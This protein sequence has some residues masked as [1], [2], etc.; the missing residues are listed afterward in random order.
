VS[1]A[2]PGDGRRGHGPP[3]DEPPEW[4]APRRPAFG[5]RPGPSVFDDPPPP[6]PDRRDA[7]RSRRISADDELHYGAETR[8]RARHLGL[9]GPP[10]R[11]R[12]GEVGARPGPARLDPRVSWYESDAPTGEHPIADD[13]FGPP[14][15]SPGT[16][17]HPAVAPPGAPPEAPPETAVPEPPSSQRASML[18]AAGILLSR[19]SGLFREVVIG[20]YLGTSAAADAFKAALRVPNLMQN[21]LGEGVLSASFIPVYARLRAEGDHETARKVA[22]SVAGLLIV[23]AGGLSLIGV[24]FAEPVTRV[25]VFGYGGERFDLTVELVRIMFPG[26]GFLVLSAWCLGVLNSHR[27]FFLSYVAPVLWNAAQ[28][29]VLVTVALAGVSRRD[30]AVALAWGVLAGGVLQ[31]AVQ[32]P[33]VLRLLGGLRLSLSTSNPAVRSVLA[34]FGPVVMGRGVVQ[35]MGYVDLLLASFLVQGGVSSL[36][37]A[38]VLYLLPIS[39]FGMSVA[40]AELPSLSSVDVSDPDRRRSFRRRM[41][42]GMARILFYVAPTATL[43]LVVGDVIV[44]ALFQRGAM[45]PDD[46]VVIWFV[47]AAFSLGLP[48]MTTSRLLQNA[49]YAL[50][51]ARTPARLAALR[52]ITSAVIGLAIM[53]P[54]DR[55]TVVDGTVQGWGDLLSLGP[56][57]AAVREDPTAPHLGILGLALGAA[58][59]AWIEYRLL[60]RSVAW[61]IGR[62]RI[63]GRWLG[64]IA[65]AC[66]V[67]ALVAFGADL[68]VGGLHPLVVAPLVLGSAGIAYLGVT[69]ALGIPEADA[70][71]GRVLRLAR[72]R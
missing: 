22:G 57:P 49:L 5:E 55:L 71:V 35:I 32:L 66:I 45:T 26:I 29:V 58:V 19:L 12:I 30:M 67:T 53:F 6:A 51:D 14:P 68:L 62:S 61:R 4:E 46:T 17:E 39:V 69:Q 13:V 63:G 65:T 11:D 43:F 10:E 36:T 16:G 50:D 56:L 25:I 41:E 60:S 59:A 52:V 24:L 72:R 18:V 7:W 21:L 54:L 1:G 48:A 40:A 23:F 37:Y 15:E 27:R 8:R 34:R 3:E 33:S 38:Q 42:D 44:R 64:P 2:G 20:R 47:I 70:L 9:G 28:I 31:C